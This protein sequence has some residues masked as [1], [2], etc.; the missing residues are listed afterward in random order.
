M[1]RIC[2]ESFLS[3]TALIV[4]SSSSPPH[5][6][7]GLEKRARGGGCAGISASV[8]HYHCLLSLY[9]PIGMGGRHQ[10][11]YRL[12]SRGVFFPS[13]FQGPPRMTMALFSP[14]GNTRP[15]VVGRFWVQNV[16]GPQGVQVQVKNIQRPL[17]CF[18]RLHGWARGLSWLAAMES[19]GFVIVIMPL[20]CFPTT[21]IQ[22]ADIKSHTQKIN[23]RDLLPQA[24][25]KRPTQNHGRTP[26]RKSLMP[27]LYHTSLASSIYTC[28]WLPESRYMDVP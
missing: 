2:A 7:G 24:A 16:K 20:I 14:R 6:V 13:G 22:F 28:V 1:A 5:R 25:W 26:R 11:R 4:Y 12:Y 21:T 23:H 9:H 18:Y 19:P 10:S 17:A 15:R 8:C 27:W 3:A